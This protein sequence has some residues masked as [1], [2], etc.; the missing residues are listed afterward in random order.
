MKIQITFKDPDSLYEA[1]TGSLEDLKI[2]GVSEDEMRAIR[3]SRAEE[4]QSIAHNWFKYGEYLT[5]EMDTD[6]KTC[7]V[8]ENNN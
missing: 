1:I 8:V 4:Y 5:V 6:L 3:Q 7:V 2:D